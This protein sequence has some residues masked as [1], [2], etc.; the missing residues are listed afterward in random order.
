[1]PGLVS[2]LQT[3]T[4]EATVAGVFLGVFPTAVAYI[5]Y[6][7]VF[8]RMSAPVAVSFLYLIP[9]MAFLIAWFWLGEAPTLLSVVGGLLTLSGVLIVNTRGRRR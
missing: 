1:M 4:P 2:A 5:T 7:Y 6:A 3:A 8:S 9:V